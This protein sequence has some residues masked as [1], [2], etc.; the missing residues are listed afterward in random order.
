LK[1]GFFYV[2]SRTWWN[3]QLAICFRSF[4]PVS[5]PEKSRTDES[6]EAYSEIIPPLAPPDIFDPVIEAYKK[7]VDRTLLRES[8]KLS[9]SQRAERML[10]TIRG[11]E[12]YRRQQGWR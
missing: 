5:D 12:E 7:D 2:W 3:W 1:V 8:L 4:R 11:I 6:R 9:P 10:A